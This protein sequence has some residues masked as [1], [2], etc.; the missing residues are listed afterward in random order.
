MSITI[1]TVTINRNPS[2]GTVWHNERM[3]QETGITADGGR[4]TYDNG[5][6]LL[7]GTIILRGVAKSEGDSLLT[8]LSGTAV[9]G[10]NSFTITPPTGCDL[11]AGSGTAVTSAYWNGGNTTEGFLDMSPNSALYTITFPY[12]KLVS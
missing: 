6:T 2:I 10:K 9:F 1:G 4:V 11:G 7:L 8:Y 5:P 3:N 12:W